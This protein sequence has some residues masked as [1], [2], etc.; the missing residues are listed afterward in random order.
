[1]KYKIG[2]ADLRHY[3]GDE[4]EVHHWFNQNIFASLMPIARHFN[5][6]GSDPIY[7]RELHL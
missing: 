7:T 6:Q 2:Q 3:T 5:P 4:T 1:M